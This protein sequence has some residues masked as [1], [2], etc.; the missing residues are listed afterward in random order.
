MDKEVRRLRELALR[1]KEISTLPIQET[2]RRQWQSLND[3]QMTKP[4]VYTRDYQ[5]SMVT[6]GGE[7]TTTTEDEFYQKLECQMLCTLF[8]WEH[9][10]ADMVVDPVIYCS[11]DITNRTQIK[12]KVDSANKLEAE[13][14]ARRSNFN[15]TAEQY[16]KQI[17]D[18]GDIDKV[19]PM[20]E[21]EFDKARLNQEW[22]RA[23]EIFGG[24]LN[25]EKK[26]I[27]QIEFTPWDDLLKLLS[28]EEG[29]MDF[30]LNPELM[31]KAMKRYVDV[32]IE[33]LRQYE[34]LGILQNNNGNTLIGSG[35]LGYTNAFPMGTGMGV[36]ATES[37]GFCTDQIFTSISPELHDEF[38]TQ[39]EIRW[40]E[41]FGLTYYGCCECLNHKIN[42]LRKFKNLRK[43][44]ISPFSDK[45][46]AMEMIG[47]D[48]VVSFKPNSILLANDTWDMEASKKEIIEACK[49]AEKYGCNIEIVM[50]TMITL[51]NQPQR[52]WQWCKMVSEITACM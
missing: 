46:R 39:H 6:L 35:A 48:Y 21:I 24:I 7:L 51:N 12:Y 29:M 40:M 45:E 13:I 49:L 37:W 15:N 2:R 32:H 33:L 5:W 23:S 9:I 43:I 50:K 20:P 11:A 25:V 36:K 41:Q 1:V 42:L 26:G 14:T 10:Q 44:S 17:F 19:I 30:Y 47:R 31:H 27:T 18:E 4:M 3:L 52:L 34:N 38:G 22:E 16:L 8:M 28:I